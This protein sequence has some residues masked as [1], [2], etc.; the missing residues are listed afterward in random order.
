MCLW[1]QMSDKVFY[2]CR[3]LIRLAAIPF[4]GIKRTIKPSPAAVATPSCTQ[5]K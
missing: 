2:T 4:K 5:R 1:F 3:D